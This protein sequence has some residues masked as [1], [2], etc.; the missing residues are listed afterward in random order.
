MYISVFMYLI[1]CVCVCVYPFMCVFVFIFDPPPHSLVTDAG[2]FMSP[3]LIGS[4]KVAG[5]IKRQVLK[6]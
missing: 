6:E 1:V 5:R 3:K 2:L 4:A